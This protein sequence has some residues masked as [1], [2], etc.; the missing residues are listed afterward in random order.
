MR[1]TLDVEGRSFF[2]SLKLNNIFL[3]R[4]SGRSA[5]FEVEMEKIRD[6]DSDPKN[7][8]YS[9]TGK[10]VMA[11]MAADLDFHY[12][13][14]CETSNADSVV[15]FLQGKIIKKQITAAPHA[16]LGKV[17]ED[18]R[19]VKKTDLVLY[20]NLPYKTER[21]TNMVKGFES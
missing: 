17:V 15:Y 5:V 11:P 20:Y 10:I 14:P 2:S 1:P 21:F 3:I 9:E 18:L 19:L 16:D 6:K 12:F 4:V 8:T 13:L 7:P